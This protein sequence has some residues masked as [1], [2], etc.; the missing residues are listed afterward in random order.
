MLLQSVSTGLVSAS[1][2]VSDGSG[3]EKQLV[4][5]RAPNSESTEPVKD[6]CTKHLWIVE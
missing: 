2:R 5:L 3:R 6:V 1:E 4:D